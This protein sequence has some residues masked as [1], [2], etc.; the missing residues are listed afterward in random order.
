MV[1]CENAKYFATIQTRVCLKLSSY[2]VQ[3]ETYIQDHATYKINKHTNK[4]TNKHH[5]KGVTKLKIYHV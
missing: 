1:F 3:I 2:Y 4:Q 5:T